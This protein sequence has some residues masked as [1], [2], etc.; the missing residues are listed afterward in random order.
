MGL[1]VSTSKTTIMI[2]QKTLTPQ[3][4]SSLHKQSSATGS[5][6]THI[7]RAHTAPNLHTHHITTHQTHTHTHTHKHHTTPIT[8]KHTNPHLNPSCTGGDLLLINVYALQYEECFVHDKWMW[9]CM[10]KPLSNSNVPIHTLLHEHKCTQSCYLGVM[11][12]HIHFYLQNSLRT[13]TLHCS[14]LATSEPL[15]G[16]KASLIISL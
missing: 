8:H 12:L 6:N 7:Q 15:F 11:H 4:S 2:K 1:A 3:A 10:C 14:F 13:T 16:V 5:E 9:M